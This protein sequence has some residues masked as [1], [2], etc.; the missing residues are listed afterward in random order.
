MPSQVRGFVLV[1]LHITDNGQPGVCSAKSE[2][3]CPFNNHPH[4]DTQKEA[5]RYS[6][7]LFEQRYYEDTKF[8]GR[9]D[10]GR[11]WRRSNE[12][13][14]SLFANGDD[15]LLD[16]KAEMTIYA[17]VVPSLNKSISDTALKELYTTKVGD[18][19]RAVMVR[20]EEWRN[21]PDS[22]GM[23]KDLHKIFDIKGHF[24][25]KNT[26]QKVYVRDYNFHKYFEENG[27]EKLI[28]Y[29]NGRYSRV[30]GVK[31]SQEFYLNPDN[32]TEPI[33]QHFLEE[34]LQDME[35]AYYDGDDRYDYYTE[36]TGGT[37]IQHYAAVD[38][39]DL[40][41]F[42]RD[43]VG[44]ATEFFSSER[45]DAKYLIT[46]PTRSGK[47]FMSANIVKEMFMKTPEKKQCA[48]VVSGYAEIEREW[49]K[50]FESHKSF[51]N[52]EYGTAATNRCGQSP[53]VCVSPIVYLSKDDFLR[54]ENAIET[55]YKNGAENI[56]VFMTLQDLAGSTNPSGK[57]VK[58][59]HKFLMA[60][61]AVDMVVADEAH[62]A[63]FTEGG[64]YN[65]VLN[66]SDIDVREKVDGP[67]DEV[68]DEA[69]QF[70]KAVKPNIGTLYVT[71][72]PFNI[73][74][75][76]TDFQLDVNASIVTEK[77][78]WDEKEEW[79]EKWLPKKPDNMSPDDWEDYLSTNPEGFKQEH[80]NPCYGIPNKKFFGINLGTDPNI[81]L[82]P[83]DVNDGDAGFIRQK[84]VE[85][86][87]DGFF[88]NIMRDEVFQ[89]AGCGNHVYVSL[90][91]CASCDGME[92]V[93]NDY[94]QR[95]GLQDEYEILNISSTK[96]AKHPV[97]KL[98]A[99]GVAN[100]ITKSGKSG[101]KTITLTVNRMGTGVTVKEWDTVVM[102][103]TVGSA[104]KFVQT[105]GRAGTPYITKQSNWN[106]EQTLC[107]NCKER[108][109]RA[110]NKFL[111]A[112]CFETGNGEVNGDQFEHLMADETFYQVEKPNAA[113]ISFSPT[114]M[115]EV[116]YA[117]ANAVAANRTFTGVNDVAKR[118]LDEELRDYYD[119]NNTYIYDF[120][121]DG[122][123]L[124]VID[125]NNVLGAVLGNVRN[126]NANQLASGLSV[127]LSNLTEQQ[128][129][130]VDSYMKLKRGK[131]SMEAY[132]GYV[133]A[134]FC[135]A[136]G[137]EEETANNKVNLCDT[138]LNEMLSGVEIQTE[139]NKKYRSNLKPVSTVLT[140][141]EYEKLEGITRKKQYLN[142]KEK[143]RGMYANIIMYATLVKELP[144]ASVEGV[145]DSIR[146]G[147][148]FNGEPAARLAEH[149]GVT[150]EMVELLKKEKVC[151]I[152]LSNT[153]ALARNG[154]YEN[155]DRQQRWESFDNLVGSLDRFSSNEIPTPRAVSK[156][157][158][159]GLEVTEKYW[160]ILSK[161]EATGVVDV[162]CKT[163]VNLVEFYDNAVAAGV[164]HRILRDKMFSV[165]TSA[166]TFELVRSVYEMHDWN[167]DNIMFVDGVSSETMREAMLLK[168][169]LNGCRAADK[170]QCPYHGKG[171][172]TV[173]KENVLNAY[174]QLLGKIENE[175]IRSQLERKLNSMPN[176][177]FDYCLSNPPYQDSGV[178]DNQ[179]PP[180]YQNFVDFG[181]SMSSTSSFIVK[182]NWMKVMGDKANKLSVWRE[183]LFDSGKVKSVDNVG[184]VF[185]KA[186]V[187]TSIITVDNTKTD[188]GKFIL[189]GM[190]TDVPVNGSPILSME[191]SA[192]LE[193][194]KAVTDSNLGSRAENYRSYAVSRK[195][196]REARDNNRGSVRVLTFHEK[197]RVK[198]NAPKAVIRDDAP[199]REFLG[200]FKVAWADIR[201]WQQNTNGWVYRLGKNEIAGEG[202]S[203]LSF[204][205]KEEVDNYLKYVK[206]KTWKFFC[207]LSRDNKEDRNGHLLF[208]PD[209]KDY[210]NNN[211]KINWKLPLDSQLYK[212]FNFTDDEIKMIEDQN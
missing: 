161:G 87:V 195:A 45:K 126:K 30:N 38:E 67:T 95:N 28:E 206:T 170:K 189:N 118:N 125:G 197:K 116:Q 186:S 7:M 59:V 139:N 4:F 47:S 9:V 150:A 90:P 46:A 208:V 141:K 107:R 180:I 106:H 86:M 13:V 39:Y 76:S 50:T 165:P 109:I 111:C 172:H 185:P 81:M 31:P 168:A 102:M 140:A 52:K 85:N 2:E 3:N 115:L 194:T 93:M 191:H 148:H 80:E 44:K 117:N 1:K 156:K 187:T 124:Q 33:F 196:L 25:D 99:N 19:K 78:I 152:D 42:Q 98:T 82:Q 136:K 77:E 54:D 110:E 119:T 40:R 108:D 100:R 57:G 70:L 122:N 101:K 131:T 210:T 162:S 202:F 75:N 27:W 193:K 205:T 128:L 201:P 143:V 23:Y 192:M 34:A 159:D 55:A 69:A 157:L 132:H 121:K 113:I 133:M 74:T 175:E 142:R 167:M 97:T 88:N 18:T 137:C 177:R 190:E 83:M 127:N 212:L 48:L 200:K 207:E 182:D 41:A 164:S 204:D 173:Q 11:K 138:H 73:L 163:G 209:L 29:D 169:E 65:D 26:G 51:N 145:I 92:K 149:L 112:E 154:F 37:I 22:N 60:D 199:S 130:S 58:N 5:Y 21:D 184:K 146:N 96:G 211:K 35:N 12:N 63:V 64:R 89:D 61:G 105:T 24:F 158:Y 56:V 14:V 91:Y 188:D 123:N 160:N 84:E 198:R 8:R 155:S 68:A 20:M 174:N 166:R 153:I 129:K 62:F 135:V 104:E 203:A 171:S 66:E 17:F 71:A 144:D 147:V 178:A 10:A 181:A 151:G 32:T 43:I 79:D 134:R 183:K 16:A 103:R 114:Q 15:V 6:E 72:T 120:T 49:R 176:T 53:C 94:L 36:L 179:A